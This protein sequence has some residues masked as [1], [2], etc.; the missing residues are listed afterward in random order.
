M[1]NTP[2]SKPGGDLASYI[3]G[4]GEMYVAGE[5]FGANYG[6]IEGATFVRDALAIYAGRELRH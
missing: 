4:L 2:A 3:T 5:R 1:P 6:G